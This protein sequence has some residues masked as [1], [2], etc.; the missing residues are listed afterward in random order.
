MANAWNKTDLQ[1]NYK[2]DLVMRE[3]PEGN[4]S[5]VKTGA[6]SPAHTLSQ[7]LYVAVQSS[8]GEFALRSSFGA[9]PKRFHGKPISRALIS[10]LQSFVLNSLKRSN[11]NADGFPMQVTAV[12]ISRTAIAMQVKVTHPRNTD[13]PIAVIRMMY[14]TT[15]NSVSPL[16]NGY[17]G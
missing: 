16:Y 7:S 13:T 5:I 15:D 17:G 6:V 12:P 2:Y 8:L 10:E 3:D 11:I 14:S 4:A 1:V 9:S